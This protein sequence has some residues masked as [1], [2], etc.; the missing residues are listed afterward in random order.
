MV[1][2]PR[3]QEDVTAP[4][5]QGR[6]SD[7]A[8]RKR[9][10]EGQQS[11]SAASQEE[12]STFSQGSGITNILGNPRQLQLFSFWVQCVGSTHNLLGFSKELESQLQL[13]PL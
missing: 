6:A 1:A 4:S 3:L 10:S 5:T 11:S 2:K 8:A 13:Y 12:T 9:P 7:G